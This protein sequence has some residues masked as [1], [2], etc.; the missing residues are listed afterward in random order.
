[1]NHALPDAMN[2]GRY[3]FLPPTQDAQCAGLPSAAY[4][5]T[6]HRSPGDAIDA[7]I[8]SAFMDAKLAEAPIRSPLVSEAP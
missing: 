3:G 7:E 6:A 1:V 2:A 5:A 4:D 8:A